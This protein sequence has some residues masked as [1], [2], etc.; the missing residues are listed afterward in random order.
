MSCSWPWTLLTV[1]QMVT[2]LRDMVSAVSMAMPDNI[3][4]C[5]LLASVSSR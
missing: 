5:I 1:L 4:V 3:E 2:L